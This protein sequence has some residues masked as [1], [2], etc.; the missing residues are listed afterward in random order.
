MMTCSSSVPKEGSVIRASEYATRGDY[1]K[2]LDPNWSY[3]PIYV[4]KMAWIEQYVHQRVPKDWHILDVGCG[5]GLLVEKF[6]A[7]GYQI[8]GVDLNYGSSFVH[9]GDLCRLPYPTG[10]FDLLFCLDAIEHLDLLS[11][12]TAL[13][14]MARVL[15]PGGQAVFAIPNLAHLESRWNFLRRGQLLRTANIKKHPGDRPIGEYLTMMTH[16]GFR[17]VECTGIKM[18]LPEGIRSWLGHKLSERIVYWT[19]APAS[20]CFL[21]ILVCQKKDG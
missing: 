8:W 9:L 4:R 5:E 1:H 13:D 7:E 20:L 19:G 21:N 2:K 16:A 14:E 11:Q 12:Q 17:L 10:T 15:R 18:T 3:Y 6:A